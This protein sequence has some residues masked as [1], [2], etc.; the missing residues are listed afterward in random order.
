MK[1]K[2]Q[3]EILIRALYIASLDSEF[4]LSE[5]LDET[6]DSSLKNDE[7]YL[8]FKQELSDWFNNL[9]D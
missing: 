5:I 4:G 7:N 9:K 8:E 3:I 1:T 2:L 6:I